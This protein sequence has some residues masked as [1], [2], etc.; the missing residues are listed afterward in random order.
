MVK[1]V[2]VGVCCKG[3]SHSG[4]VA[5]VWWLS[6]GGC[7]SEREGRSNLHFAVTKQRC[8]RRLVELREACIRNCIHSSVRE[9]PTKVVS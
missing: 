8:A 1:K 7:R 2:A 3:L 4:I 6:L 5:C 9:G